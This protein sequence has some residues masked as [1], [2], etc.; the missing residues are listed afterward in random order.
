VL[1]TNDSDLCEPVNLVRHRLGKIVGVLNPQ[2]HPA[3]AL[4]KVATFFK[5]IRSG[6]LQV[7]QFPDELT[8]ERG[9]FSKPAGW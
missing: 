9:T 8:D 5:S 4:V 1:I 2:K 7:S 3:A 6:V